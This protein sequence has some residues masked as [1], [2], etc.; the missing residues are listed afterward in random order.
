MKFGILLPTRWLVLTEP[1]PDNIDTI[2][3]MSLSAERAGLHS[4]WVGDS[5]TAKPR[6]EPLT[7]LSA[8]ATVTQKIKLGTS[9]LI[10]PLRHPVLLSQSASSVDVISGGRVILG[11]GV[12][13]A[14]NEAQ[15]REWLNAG[16][17]PKTRGARFE[18]MLPLIKKLTKGETVNFEGNHFNLKDVNVALS[19]PNTDG[20]RLILASHWNSGISRQIW[21]VPRLADGFI[22]ISDYPNEYKNL[23]LSIKD[24]SIDAGK[25]YDSMDKVFY[26]TININSDVDHATSEADKFLNQYYGMNIW[27]DRWGPYGTTEHIVERIRQYQS[28]GAE[29]VVIRFAA[30]DQERQMELF[31]NEILTEF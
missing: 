14:F 4:V 17:N 22:S 6:L 28:C 29:T 25:D 15:R 9:V 13:G 12:G 3:R 20:V 10:A 21:R 24:Q 8:L 11:L 1:K 27:G 30:F 26:M 19:S 18:E 2:I 31:I 5:L 23:A 16:V 7:I